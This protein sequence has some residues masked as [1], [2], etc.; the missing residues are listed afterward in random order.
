GAGAALEGAEHRYESS[1]RFTATVRTAGGD[2]IVFVL[3]RD[4]LRWRLSDIRL[5]L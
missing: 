3:T 5:P 1:S 2:P 4:G